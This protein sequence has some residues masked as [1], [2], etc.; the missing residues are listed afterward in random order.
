MTKPA[1]TYPSSWALVWADE[2]DGDAIDR[3]VWLHEVNSWGGGNRELQYYTAR[4]ENSFLRDGCLVLRARRE[5]Y[6]GS[7]G[8]VR[9]Y[10][11][12]R[13]N[14]RFRFTI[15]FGR[16]ETRAR[17][18]G[19]Q[20]LWPAIWMLPTYHVHGGWPNSGEIDIMEH[21]GDMPH[22]V[23]G[24][25]HYLGGDLKRELKGGTRDMPEDLSD[26]FHVYA[27]EWEVGEIRWYIDGEEY[28]RVNDW[29]SPVAP[30]P[31]PFNEE[32][33]LVVNVAVGGTFLPDPPENPDYFPRE[34]EIDYI[35]VYQR[36]GVLDYHL[37]GE[38][39]AGHQTTPAGSPNE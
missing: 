34:M 19:G 15:R 18:P 22:R 6:E 14:T 21:R 20:G 10:T 33:H 7:D 36:P 37:K 8:E 38:H 23:F 35:R 25:I 3:D 1:A 11:S 39:V 24:T 13:L 12:A 17:V 32:F 31:A 29:S 27:I 16:V 30:F 9:F 4:P 28:F 5:I 26:D 2:F